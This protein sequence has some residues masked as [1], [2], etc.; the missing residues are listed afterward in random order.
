VALSGGFLCL[1]GLFG[2]GLGTVIR[3]GAGA[4]AAFAAC[5][6]A[7]PL[8]LGGIPGHI[9]KFTPEGILQSS[10]AAA[11]TQAHQLTPWVGFGLMALYAG[12]AVAVGG[13]LLA[14]RDA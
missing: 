6:L 8:A 13:A 1:I 9:V 12:L 5:M 4:I 2:L 10:V 11:R 14:R 7:P 3:H